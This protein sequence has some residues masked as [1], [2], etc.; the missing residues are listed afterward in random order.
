LAVS[1]AC[2]NSASRETNT[3]HILSTIQPLGTYEKK[4]KHSYDS[5]KSGFLKTLALNSIGPSIG[6]RTGL[7]NE[8]KMDVERGYG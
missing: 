7:L 2:C 8:R 5:D 6:H 4:K 3:T 1:A